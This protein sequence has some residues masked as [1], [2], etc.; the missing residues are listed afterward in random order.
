VAEYTIEEIEAA[1]Q[2]L[3]QTPDGEAILQD[4]RDHIDGNPADFE[5]THRTFYKL[6]RS[7]LAKELTQRIRNS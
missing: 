3:G 1:Y 4:L 7:Q 6:G 2:R 5:S